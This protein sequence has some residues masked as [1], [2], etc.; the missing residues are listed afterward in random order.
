M[1]I[2]RSYENFTPVSLGYGVGLGNFDGVHLGHMALI[3]L[4]TEKCR[5]VQIPSMLYTFSMHPT[6]VINKMKPA[7]LIMTEEQRLDIF[8]QQGIDTVYLED[9]TEAFATLSPQRFVENI[10]VKKLHA[11][12]VVVGYDLSLIHI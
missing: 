12:I 1:T 6:H 3:D 8:E 11:R 2:V 9:F 4:L 7:P 5:E 10:L